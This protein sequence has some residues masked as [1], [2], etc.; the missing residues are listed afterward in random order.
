[1][2][3]VLIT[4]NRGFFGT[5][6][7]A[8]YDGDHTV[9]GIDKDDVDIVDA[10]AVERV[11]RE[12]RPE[13]VIHA[14][15]ITATAFSN[16]HPD[17]TRKIN[18]DGAVNVARAAREVGAKLIFF[19]T[20]QVYNGNGEPGPYTEEDEAHPDTMYG[21]TK[22]E[23]ESL[24]RDIIEELWILRFTWLF[25]LPERAMPVNPNILWNAVRIAL[26]GERTAVA[27]DEYRGHT[28]GYDMLD[29]VMKVPEIP[30]GTY[31]IGSTND[32]GRYEIT[33]AILGELGLSDSRVSELLEADTE[34]YAGKPRD[35]RLATDKIAH[36]GITFEP[37][38]AAASRA[39]AEF[40]L[41][42]AV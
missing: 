41:R 29:R 18:V 16:E 39:L 8:L 27:V 26:K 9:V 19:S 35:V 21:R 34:K 12:A 28:Y 22:L 17:L 37:S 32:L 7:H 5:R 36:H 25:G 4:G 30:Y 11:V 3:R 1:M 20:E 24:L 40:G 42:G 31:H 38:L 15:A 33:R 13:L 6:F 14:A 10:E 23:A 2:A